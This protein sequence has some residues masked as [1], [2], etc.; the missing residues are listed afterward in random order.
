MLSLLIDLI[1]ICIVGGLFWWIL[2]M[3][4]LPAPAKQ[5]ATVVLVVI[6]AIALIYLLLGAVH[7][8]PSLG[9]RLG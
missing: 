9:S 4:P 2:Q 8:G 1:V 6:L 7:G 3:V 5:I